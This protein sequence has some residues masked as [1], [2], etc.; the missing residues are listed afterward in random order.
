MLAQVHCKRM[1]AEAASGR[2]VVLTSIVIAAA[3]LI[4][5]W[6][7][8]D[9]RTFA[10]LSTVLIAVWVVLAARMGGARETAR[11]EWRWIKRKLGF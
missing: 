7:I 11:A 4:T 10:F 3:M 5:A 9:R 1:P 6:L 8:E 2:K